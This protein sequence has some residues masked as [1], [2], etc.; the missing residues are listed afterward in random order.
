MTVTE[1]VEF[2]AEHTDV[3]RGLEPLMAVGLGYVKLGQPVPES[4]F[5]VEPNSPAPQA[6]QR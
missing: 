2:F 1:A 5:A 6:A 4:N 3:R